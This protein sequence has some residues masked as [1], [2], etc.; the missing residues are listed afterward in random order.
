MAKAAAAGGCRHTDSRHTDSRHTQAWL[1]QQHLEG[2]QRKKQRQILSQQQQQQVEVEEGRGEET[3]QTPPLGIL[4]KTPGV[5]RAEYEP[6]WG[7]VQGAVEI[8]TGL[9]VGWCL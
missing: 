1:E 9:L 8:L 6:C 2:V 7:K 5:L 4:L 3:S